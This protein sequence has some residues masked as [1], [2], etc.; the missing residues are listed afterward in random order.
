MEGFRLKDIPCAINKYHEKNIDTVSRIP[1]TL[2]IGIALLS[3]G[4]S[5]ITCAGPAIVI[6]SPAN[7][8]RLTQHQANVTGNTS[9]IEYQWLQTTQADF[10]TGVLE[11]LT[12]NSDGSIFLDCGKYDD[13]QDDI[14]NASKWCITE[15][16]GGMFSNETEQMYR[17]HGTSDT[18]MLWGSRT[19]MVSTRTF[20]NSVSAYCFWYCGTLSNPQESGYLTAM[21]I[22]DDNSTIELGFRC[23]KYETTRGSYLQYLYHQNYYGIGFGNPYNQNSQTFRIS[24]NS[25]AATVNSDEIYS[26]ELVLDA[27][28]KNP[29]FYFTT[30]IRYI[31]D[32]M[33]SAWDNVIGNRYYEGSFTSP[34]H[35]T[36]YTLPSLINTFWNATV[37]NGTTL[38]VMIRSSDNPDMSNSTLWTGVNN[39]QISGLPSIRR[40]LQYRV[41]FNNT[42]GLTSPALHDIAISYD[43]RPVTKVEL[44]IDNKAT[45]NSANGTSSWY[46]NLDFPENTTII[47]A[48]VT[49]PAGDF[50]IV[51]IIV[52]VDTTPPNGTF[53]INTGDI[54]TANRS[55]TLTINASDRYG[56]A[57]MMISENPT[58]GGASW[59]DFC[60]SAP[61]LLSSGDGKKTILAQ[62]RDSSGLGFILPNANIILDTTPPSS[63][64]LPMPAVV[65]TTDFTVRWNGSDELSGIQKY[66]LQYRDDDGPWI[67]WLNDIRFNVAD[68]S[69]LDGHRYSFRVRAQDVA[70]NIQEFSD[71]GSEY[72]L[73]RLPRPI[74]SI[75][76]PIENST[77]NGIVSITGVASH[78]NGSMNITKV[79]VQ[80]D[81]GAWQT[82]RGT[83]QWQ[84]QWDTAKYKNGAHTLRA[85]AFDSQ[86]L[87]NDDNK[88][89]II[90]NAK[91]SLNL[92][93][94]EFC[95]IAIAL[96][97]AVGLLY[98]GLANKRRS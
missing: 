75:I 15:N 50:D 6:I 52:D 91:P 13:F 39:S 12:T 72:I 25:T 17:A 11:N 69:G 46:I 41:L 86:N 26:M 56:I 45:W 2:L 55:V 57:S 90:K 3:G 59:Q 93:R 71:I 85:R 5:S 35:D 73:V 87:T 78:Q 42:D 43:K 64:I 37:P 67:D 10:N 27:P 89:I 19:T 22:F 28:L 30:Q 83:N 18:G 54:Y 33:E 92:D 47:W 94:M 68:F 48:M 40:Y 65:G 24:W 8:G 36:G 82:A 84:F 79:L 14:L 58:F 97:V 81:E 98:L 9:G 88:S 32:S 77:V 34:I 38:I 96:I 23:E 1:L 61:F 62:V 74:V 60:Q 16:A 21:G 51:S 29:R 7:G 53:I 49:H 66:D 4:Y 44:S 70:G 80:I 20:N 76:K 63:S 95:Y 31:G